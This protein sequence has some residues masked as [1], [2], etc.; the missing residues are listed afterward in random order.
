MVIGRYEEIK[1]IFKIGQVLTNA[2]T[3]KYVVIGVE[4]QFRIVLQE[5]GSSQKV[6]ASNPS[7]YKIYNGECFLKGFEVLS[8]GSGRYFQNNYNI[9]D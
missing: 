4:S 3:S 5:I 9:K 1:H 6:R 7:M 2:N 8:W